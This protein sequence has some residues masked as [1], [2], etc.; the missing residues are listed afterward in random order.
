[1]RR[2]KARSAVIAGGIGLGGLVGGV[3]GGI[4]GALAGE[5]YSATIDSAEGA[6]F[7]DESRDQARLHFALGGIVMGGCVGAMVGN[8]I[9][10]RAIPRTEE[11][12]S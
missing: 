2:G 12:E 10:E 5:A 6:N 1:M 7:S 3:G 11:N 4:V 9:R 8:S